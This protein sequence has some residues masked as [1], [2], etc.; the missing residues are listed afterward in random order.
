VV[1]DT[2]GEPIAA[3]RDKHRAPERSAS[4]LEAGPSMWAAQGTK[5]EGKCQINVFLVAQIP[6]PISVFRGGGG[7]REIFGGKK[8]TQNPFPPKP[9][10]VLDAT[11]Q[12]LVARDMCTAGLGRQFLAILLNS[13]FTSALFTYI[14]LLT[15]SH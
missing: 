10:Q 5:F 1:S 7:G 4:I 9:P 6:Q 8:G 14:T 11:V 13:H 15:D 2:V 12:N 3:K